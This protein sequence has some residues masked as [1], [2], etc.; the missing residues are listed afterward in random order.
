MSF[1]RSSMP[2][3]D[4]E[5]ERQRLAAMERER[6][7]QERLASLEAEEKSARARGL[8]GARSLLSA[9]FS[10]FDRLGG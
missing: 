1:G 4:P 8:R 2:K 7:E 6:K 3:P 5:I 10:G 9:G